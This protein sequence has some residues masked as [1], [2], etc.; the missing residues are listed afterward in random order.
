[1]TVK[2]LLTI[3]FFGLLTSS[4]SQQKTMWNKWNW[5]TGEWVGD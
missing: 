4:F 5:L 1:M 2:L 3:T